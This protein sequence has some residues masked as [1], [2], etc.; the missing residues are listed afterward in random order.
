MQLI[1]IDPSDDPSDG[2]EG[3]YFRQTVITQVLIV[4]FVLVFHPRL[5]PVPAGSRP[6]FTARPSRGLREPSGPTAS[7]AP[8]SRHTL[9]AFNWIGI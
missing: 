9:V 4:E 6:G 7:G 8:G 1:G 3:F 5:R 2:V